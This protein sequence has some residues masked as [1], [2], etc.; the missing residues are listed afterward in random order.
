VADG[1]FDIRPTTS[2]ARLL[3]ELGLRVR[4]TPD[5][6]V[7][8]AEV[9][10]AS[11]P[12]TLLRPV[13]LDSIRLVFELRARNVLLLNVADLPPRQAGRSVFAFDNLRDDEESGRLH[14]G[15]SV[16]GVRTGDAVKLVS[17]NSYTHTFATPTAAAT[18]AITD[19]FGARAATVDAV[20]ADVGT[21]MTEYRI[22]LSA[23]D[24]QAG[25]Y[26][27]DD[28]LGTVTNFYYD[29][30]L[31][32]SRPL[33]VIDVYTHT[34]TVTPDATNR[35]P[36]AYRFLSGDTL[37]GFDAYYI[38]FEPLATT[39]RYIVTK[40]YDTNGI[41]LTDL[42][43]DGPISFS[44]S[45]SGTRAVFTSS[46]AVSLSATARGLRLMKDATDPV[47]EL[48]EPGLS[49]PLGRGATP[50]DFVSD[51]FVYV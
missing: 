47:R 51:M 9:E 45:V 37:T 23:L 49:T 22:D 29:L 8:Y 43:I 7:V 46:T 20:S 34:T 35:V 36:N 19:R 11:A 31:D 10:P 3:M 27:L 38:Q 33:A 2:T 32:A 50:T 1:D 44:G 26:R 13:G 6:L 14:L 15:D 24:M 12:P 17:R 41:A 30:D 21:P 25:R 5:G 48:P 16:A 39:W 40:K 18:L 28:G 4:K 42:S